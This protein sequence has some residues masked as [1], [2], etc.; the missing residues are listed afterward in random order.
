MKK[1]NMKKETDIVERQ[2]RKEKKTIL[3][4]MAWD[5]WRKVQL[6]TGIKEQLVSRVV[7]RDLK[8]VTE[9]AMK[10]RKKLCLRRRNQA[11]NWTCH[12]ETH[13]L[14]GD[15]DIITI[16]R[17]RF[18]WETDLKMMA[19]LFSNLE[20]LNVKEGVCD[21]KY[22]CRWTATSTGISPNISAK[23][24]NQMFP[25]LVCLSGDIDIRADKIERTL[26][27]TLVTL[28]SLRHVNVKSIDAPLTMYSFPYLES[29]E[30][31]YNKPTYNLHPTKRFHMP[32]ID[33]PWKTL[34]QHL[35]LEDL[36]VR[37]DWNGY[38]EENDKRIREMGRFRWT[39]L[40]PCIT[41]VTFDSYSFSPWK[42][43]TLA[44]L[45]DH[46][47]IIR[48]LEVGV[49]SHSM[50]NDVPDPYNQ[51]DQLMSRLPFL[52]RLTVDMKT[53][54]GV[55]PHVMPVVN[56]VSLDRGRLGTLTIKLPVYADISLLPVGVVDIIIY[57]NQPSYTWVRIKRLKRD[58][59]PVIPKIKAALTDGRVKQIH[60]QRRQWTK[61]QLEV[62]KEGM[63]VTSTDDI[64]I[65]ISCTFA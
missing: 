16:C 42:E 27:N 33:I 48:E 12:D 60:L 52:E 9:S 30:V 21:S 37:V 59:E 24:I 20:V 22:V 46:G 65:I 38:K 17:G 40:F 10:E 4:L 28:A 5:L 53:W 11:S 35:T 41:K 32:Y 50:F 45:Q 64:I 26:D 6:M 23:E 44:F 1:E 31:V 8:N 34:Y 51:M 56:R 25:R 61:Q 54:N 62:F 36:N 15:K 14:F 55:Q 39:P 3:S 57:D 43:D 63:T 7:S 2:E 49:C 58:V 47:H 18:L 19:N 13:A 29:L